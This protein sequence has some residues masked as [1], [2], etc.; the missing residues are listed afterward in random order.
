MSNPKLCNYNIYGVVTCLF[1][2]RLK[3]RKKNFRSV[4]LKA[5]CFPPGCNYR[6]LFKFGR[7][8]KN[9][10]VICG[11]NGIKPWIKRFHFN[12]IGNPDTLNCELING[13]FKNGKLNEN[14]NSL[15]QYKYSYCGL[16]KYLE[17]GSSI[18]LIDKTLFRI[19]GGLFL[20]T[21]NRSPLTKGV[22]NHMEH[23]VSW[24]QFSRNNSKCVFKFDCCEHRVSAEAA[25]FW[26]SIS[27]P[28]REDFG[29]AACPICRKRIKGYPGYAFVTT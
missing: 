17:S 28:F 5:K 7:H 18:Q 15:V 9:D 16:W 25:I 23:D 8:P 26:T 2:N 20:F 6:Q 12:I 1:K 19:R 4:V 27:L 10:F 29:G 24:L 21:S 3:S 22:L 14:T 13:C 11:K